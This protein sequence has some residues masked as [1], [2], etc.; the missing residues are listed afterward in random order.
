MRPSATRLLS[1]G[2]RSI[3][4]GTAAVQANC[5]PKASASD[6]YCRVVRRFEHKAAI[7]RALRDKPTRPT[8][9]EDDDVDLRPEPAQAVAIVL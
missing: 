5:N 6:L 7:V 4:A 3:M 1:R 9:L 8:P 2:W